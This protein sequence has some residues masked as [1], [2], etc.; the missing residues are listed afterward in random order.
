MNVNGGVRTLGSISDYL[1]ID[2]N[3]YGEV[4]INNYGGDVNANNVGGS[5]NV[6]SV[7]GHIYVGDNV[8]EYVE[9]GGNVS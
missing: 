6:N 3:V 8:G 1:H 5:I 4:Y 9:I 2:G 7:G